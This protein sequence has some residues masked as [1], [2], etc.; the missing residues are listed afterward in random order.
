MVEVFISR[1]AMIFLSCFAVTTH[2]QQLNPPVCLSWPS[3]PP[4]S[5]ENPLCGNGIKDAG[6]L[7][8]DGNRINNDGCNAWCNAFDGLTSTCTLAGKNMAC[9]TGK[10]EFNGAGHPARITFCNLRAMDID[11]LQGKYL[12]LADE[13]TILRME[14]FTDQ[15]SSSIT[16]LNV[17]S[18]KNFNPICS[19]SIF[20]DDLS[21]LIYECT[22]P[23][24]AQ[25][26]RENGDNLMLSLVPPSGYG[27]ISIAN[28]KDLFHPI[29]SN[30]IYAPPPYPKILSI[31]DQRDVLVA[32]VSTNSSA[33]TFTPFDFC[34][35]LYRIHI[36]AY[37]TFQEN[38]VTDPGLYNSKQ[39]LFDKSNLIPY[40]RIP[41]IIYNVAEA[42]G[43]KKYTAY[44]TKDMVPKYIVRESCIHSYISDSKCFV[45]HMARHSDL[46]FLSAYIPE[47][48]GYDI[49]YV[50]HSDI[51]DNALGFPITR[52]GTH[53]ISKM[54]YMLR[55]AC[56]QSQNLNPGTSSRTPDPISLGNICN[57]VRTGNALECSAPFNNP[58]ITDIVASPKLLPENLNSM[59]T[60]WA[61]KQIFSQVSATASIN[62]TAEVANAVPDEG[63]TISNA[64]FYQNLLKD[65]YGN[66]TPVDFV[67]VPSTQDIIYITPISVGL[68]GTRQFQLFDPRNRGYCKVNDM[69]YCPPE[70]FGSVQDG[71]CFS[72]SESTSPGFGISVAW[73]I[74]CASN[75]LPKLTPQQKKNLV[76][77]TILTGQHAETGERYSTLVSNQV[78][79]SI[80]YEA[81]CAFIQTTNQTCPERAQSTLAP[82]QQ[83]NWEADREATASS[84]RDGPNT[85]SFIQK[86]IQRAESRLSRNITTKNSPGE[87]ISTWNSQG[88]AILRASA[89][90]F[91]TIK[92]RGGFNGFQN[93]TIQNKTYTYNETK[94][95]NACLFNQNGNQ[96]TKWLQCAIPFILNSTFSSSQAQVQRRLLDVA[97]QPNAS[98]ARINA[99]QDL[100]LTSDSPI[101]YNPTTSNTDQDDPIYV[102]PPNNSNDA[103]GESFP[104]WAGIIVGVAGCIVIL[105][106]IGCQFKTRIPLALKASSLYS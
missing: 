73:Q 105:I 28:F 76:P 32:G 4:T 106:L 71:A 19:I 8:D 102:P 26:R 10:T 72:C 51:M 23:A 74:K 12:L 5:T 30:P 64:I 21:F 93:V 6:E 96:I 46:H 50:L 40:A 70:F 77:A 97:E 14:L 47:N 9:P 36:P 17:N 31:P 48:G 45:V 57:N 85:A 63:E 81:I 99:N 11:P 82:K 95:I 60:H 59:D 29:S 7:C 90:I 38:M 67:E 88:N 65:M 41:C 18:E 75:T 86:L 54:K 2:S 37:K 13:S 25:Q 27:L 22:S 62:A 15:T 49:A 84:I 92:A 3:T 100:T 56:F 94:L 42:K 52:Y 44:S 80:M 39:A 1:F 79:E 34:V 55:G 66:S 68:I 98:D 87:Y 78:D 104:L 83:F 43:I 20:P 61:L 24:N 16:S 53:P 33:S 69:L 58:F 101:L 91:Q 103:R 89:Q 35:D